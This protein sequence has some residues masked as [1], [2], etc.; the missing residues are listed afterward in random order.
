MTTRRTTEAP[1]P[2]PARRRGRAAGG[3]LVGIF[4]GLVLGLALAAGVAY[5]FMRAP[6]PYQ[7]PT[8]APA[9]EPAREPAKVGKGEPPAGEKPRFDFY[10]ILPGGEEPKQQPKAAEKTPDKAAPDRA[11]VERA[12]PEVAA[13]A[14][15]PADRFWL[16]AGSFAAE[17][18]AENLKAQLALSG[19]E[20]VVQPATL[21]DKGLRYRV[22]VGPYD[23]TDELNRI[24]AELSRRGFDVAVIKY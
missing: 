24:K 10:R 2:R 4:I 21:P 20:A 22:R 18:D 7:A 5:Y 12:T 23:N 11:T 6:S 14:A 9:R 16:Q 13:K 8:A 17:A 15:K 19:W 3:V 1:N